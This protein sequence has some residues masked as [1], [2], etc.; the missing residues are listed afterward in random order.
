MDKINQVDILL[1]TYN[2]EKHL[3]ELLDSLLNQTF[4]DFRILIADDA[5]TDGTRKVLQKYR[6]DHPDK[7]LYMA[8][9]DNVGVIGNFSRLGDLSD[10][11]YVMFSDQ[12]D[13]WFPNKIAATLDNMKKAEVEYGAD[14][15]LCVHSDIVV[16]DEDLKI[17]APSFRR[18]VPID[19]TRIKL[20]QALMGTPNMGCASMINRKMLQLAFPIPLEAAMHDFWMALVGSAFGK[21][22]PFDDK[23]L[24]YRHHGGNFCGAFRHQP[25]KSM[26]QMLRNERYA[27][28]Q[29]RGI[30]AKMITAFVF[31]KR[32]Q[33]LLSE[34]QK[35]I[36]R[37]FIEM[38]NGSRFNE[39]K[40]RLKYG[41]LRWGFLLMLHDF[42]CLFLTG[43]LPKKYRLFV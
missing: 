42:L 31:Y 2:G 27:R 35:D 41:F 5:S 36:L 29:N 25:I 43:P 18:H 33:G 8:Y 11:P 4:Q 15:P 34:S 6:D 22:I 39:I 3:A 12:D 10:A 37:A 38:K 21:V 9:P 19:P 16:V 20:Q 7:I 30:Y 13:V 1:A 23:L 17:L 26:Y 14:I 32:Y 40:V 24:Y 28:G